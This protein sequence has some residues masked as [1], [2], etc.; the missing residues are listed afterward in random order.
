MH[1]YR[2][3]RQVG[4]ALLPLTLIGIAAMAQAQSKEA[5]KTALP[6]WK[7]L[8]TAYDYDRTAALS[9]KEEPVENPDAMI[10]KITFLGAN[11]ERIPGIFARPKAVGVYPCVLLLHG[12]TSDKETMAFAF[13]TPLVK[14][15]YAFLALDAPHHGA[16]KVAGEKQAD[17]KNFTEAVKLGCRDYRRGLDWLLARKD[18]NKDHIG[19]LGYSMGAMMGSILTAVDS[20][21]M[22]SALCV[23]G[24][25]V[26]PN[27]AA[28]PAEFKEVVYT[29][30]PSLYI[31]HIA[32]RPL[33]MLNGKQDT[34]MPEAASKLLYAAAKEP[35]KIEWFDSGHILPKEA[36]EKAIDWLATKL[37]PTLKTSR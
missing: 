25:P 5:V 17:P 3:F 7:T 28:I 10:V 30:S 36:G 21:I 1:I 22:A 32:P 15:G 6:D 11:G 4:A 37:A 34:V 29:V 20:R 35:K 14:K 2:N 18:V 12:L 16:R 19:L 31:G 8:K 24:D 23:G 9:A 13:G 26:L 27:A 33:Y